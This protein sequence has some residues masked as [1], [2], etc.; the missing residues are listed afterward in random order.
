MAVK[1]DAGKCVGCGACADACPNGAITIE[2]VAVVDAD[3]CVDCGA[4]IDECRPRPSPSEILLGGGD[5]PPRQ[6]SSSPCS[7]LAS[8]IQC[9]PATCFPA[10]PDQKTLTALPPTHV[11]LR[12]GNSS[13]LPRHEKY[14]CP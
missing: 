5:P 7:L 6:T 3:K 9:R 10:E 8:N 4:C 13:S 12:S 1:I 11:A 2:D 14:Q